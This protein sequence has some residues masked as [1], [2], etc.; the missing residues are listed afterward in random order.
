MG[1][2]GDGPK[3]RGLV[4]EQELARILVQ[5]STNFLLLGWRQHSTRLSTAM[6]RTEDNE[7]KEIGMLSIN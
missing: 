4:P 2:T 5:Y 7:G 1:R 3:C 6:G